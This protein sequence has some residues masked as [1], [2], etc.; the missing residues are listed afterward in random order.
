MKEN[1][2]C[3]DGFFEEMESF[4]RTAHRGFES[5]SPQFAEYVVERLRIIIQALSSI[6]T[7]LED[8]EEDD[9][10]SSID[11]IITCC[12]SLGALWQSYIDEMDS[13]LVAAEGM[14]RFQVPRVIDGHGRPRAIVTQEQLEYLRSIHFSWSHIAELLGVSR[15]TIYRRRRDFG[16]LD[17]NIDRPMNDDEL[18]GFIGQVREEIP[19]AG[20][21]LIIGRIQSMGYRVPRDR[22]RVAIRA[23]DP[24]NTALRWRGILTSRQPYSVAGPN[25]LWHIGVCVCV[26]VLLILMC[27]YAISGPLENN[28]LFY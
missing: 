24:I 11:E 3:G 1:S 14:V 23:T 4:I 5:S 20:E 25:S 17:E 12:R 27:T 9:L 16:I 10:H 13:D 21:S 26:C 28:S 15:M 8:Q 6:L 18:R 7:P 2:L 22:V 19:S